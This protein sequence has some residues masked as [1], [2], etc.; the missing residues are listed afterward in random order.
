[1][2]TTISNLPLKSD[3]GPNDNIPIDDVTDGVGKRVRIKDITGSA[4]PSKTTSEMQATPPPSGQT[5][6]DTEVERMVLGSGTGARY[7]SGLR[8]TGKKLNTIADLQ[9][10][11]PGW[12]ETIFNETPKRYVQGYNTAGDS[13]NGVLYW[14]PSE[15]RSNHNGGRVFSPIHGVGTYGDPTSSTWH[16]PDPS[17]TGTGCWK[18]NVNEV[19][20][21]DDFGATG[22]GSVD[23]YY[24]INAALNVQRGENSSVVTLVNGTY[25]VSQT[26]IVPENRIFII[27]QDTTLRPQTDIDVLKIS[28]NSFVSGEGQINVNNVAGYSSVALS[29]IPFDRLPGTRT[30]ASG[31]SIANSNVSGTGLELSTETG[32]LISFSTFKDI[33]ILNF[34]NGIH[35][36]SGSVFDQPKFIN[37]N[38]FENVV[39]TRCT[40]FIK[41]EGVNMCVSNIFRG[42]RIQASTISEN[43]IQFLT[44][45]KHVF[46]GYI[47]DWAV[48]ST[49]KAITISEN[50]GY[51]TVRYSG[52]RHIYI[53][54]SVSS[55]IIQ[56]TDPA[57]P[58]NLTIPP[59]SRRG[60]SFTELNDKLGYANFRDTIT[61]NTAPYL[62]SINNIFDTDNTARASWESASYLN[63][64]VIEIRLASN[65]S[66]LKSL[67]A[68]F[69]LGFPKNFKMELYS[70]A[71]S[72]Y[73][74]I[75]NTTDNHVP[76]IY[77]TTLGFS[78]PDLTNAISRIRITFSRLSSSSNS[79]DIILQRLFAYSSGNI[80]T[81]YLPR[82][83][84]EIYGNIDFY[85]GKGP[86]IESP[87]GTKYLI[88]VDN[89]GNISSTSL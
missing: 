15:P 22:G 67:G 24:A 59:A 13:G 17:D 63:D 28:I 68:Q 2:A 86:V 44:G 40:N 65:A 43:A 62:G 87:D 4:G 50:V 70:D 1:M 10:D 56:D 9:G 53:N 29:V 45:S 23:D 41:M 54:N 42:T 89:S 61:V 48:A 26:V 69:Y 20:K 88:S 79:N 3:P 84:G 21:V 7:L 60:E 39:M 76:N 12:F 27:P 64:I 33:S 51:S 81:S 5:A 75:F 72:S 73:H 32:R 14:D 47:W 38:T 71:D 35:V 36:N 55:S 49:E 85:Q 18:R 6:Y 25:E 34:E 83:G 78:N 82:G 31:I 74:T 37:S 66:G 77:Q 30:G 46:E 58:S 52:N 80:G 57:I 19:V 11:I 16:Q 8:D